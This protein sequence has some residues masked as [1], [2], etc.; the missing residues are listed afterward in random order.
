[1]LVY[2]TICSLLGGLSVAC[3]SGLGASILTSIRGENQVKHWYARCASSDE[4]LADL[5]EPLESTGSSGSCS[6]SS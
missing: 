5:T 1:M 2:I 6:D 3:T 4:S